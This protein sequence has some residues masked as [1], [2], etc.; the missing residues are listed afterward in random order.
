LKIGFVTTSYPRYKGD[1]A[2]SFIAD[3]VL[4]LR[5]LGHDVKIIAP[6]CD[7]ENNKDVIRVDFKPRLARKIAYGNG[8]WPNLKKN[9]FLFFAIPGFMKSLERT[10]REEFADREVV[11]GVFTAAGKALANARR[12]GQ[13]IVYAGHGSDIHLLGTSAIYRK[14]FQRMITSFDGVTV[15][16]QYLANKITSFFP[17]INLVVIPN[18]VSDELFNFRNEWLSVP[19]AIYSSRFIPL[20]RTDM[21][22]SSW[23]KVVKEISNAKLLLFG[24]GPL[25]PKCKEIVKQKCLENNVIFK[26]NVPQNEL[27]TEIGN[28]WVTILISEE[29]G[30]G[31]G[32]IESLACGCPFISSPCGAAPEIAEK[33]SGGVIIDEPLSVEKLAETIILAFSNKDTL[34]D[35]GMLGGEKVSEYY[36]WKNTAEMKLEFYRKTIKQAQRRVG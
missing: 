30:F 35:M 22:V 33:T 3:Q 14:Q 28:G 10:I 36:S 2:G 17:N 23:A 4:A 26:G 21:L 11:E 20:K 5:D 1:A 18:G 32:L 6:E 19:T 27:W 25:L 9:P 13:A 34:T 29:E 24:D 31:L 7:G 12:P 8:I 16:S 15:V